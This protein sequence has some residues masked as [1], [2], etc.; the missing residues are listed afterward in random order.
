MTAIQSSQ[1]NAFITQ[2][3]SEMGP[4]DLTAFVGSIGT[5]TT[6]CYL[7]IDYDSDSL[8]EVILFDGTFGASSF[9]TTSI[10]N[11]YLEGSAAGSNLTH[12][13]GAKVISTPLSMHIQDIYDLL[14]AIDHGDLAGLTDDDHP[15]YLAKTGGT[16]TGDL[17]LDADPSSDLHAATK[18]YVDAQTAGVLM[19]T[20]QADVE[21][22]NTATEVDEMTLTI[23]A[24]WTTFYVE[25][26]GSVEVD[27]IGYADGWITARVRKSD[28]TLLFD[29]LNQYYDNGH[30]EMMT[31]AAITGSLSEADFA[32]NQPI[33]IADL[34]G[35]RIIKVQLRGEYDNNG[36]STVGM[37]L[38]WTIKATKVT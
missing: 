18:Q 35:D 21:V 12:P 15:Q 26:Y 30:S 37:K 6:P 14:A 1:Q 4:N 13:L 28:N 8:R 5:L 31:S 3:T 32:T 9:V 11:R 33:S 16:L 23:P 24:D 27:P 17:T 22:S 19:K 10:S 7:V 2:L 38:N 25:M 29:W 36:G 20:G 34:L